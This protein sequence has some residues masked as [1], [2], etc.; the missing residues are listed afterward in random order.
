MNDVSAAADGSPQGRVETTDP[1]AA[2]PVPAHGGEALMGASLDVSPVTVLGGPPD[3]SVAE[4]EVPVRRRPRVR[5]EG[6]RPEESGASPVKESRRRRTGVAIATATG[7]VALAAAPFAVVTPQVRI[8]GDSAAPAAKERHTTEAKKQVAKPAGKQP[9]LPAPAPV[10]TW[11]GRHSSPP[12]PAPPPHVKLSPSS[13]PS[14]NKPHAAKPDAPKPDA[15]KADAAKAD[16]ARAG[17]QAKA[18]PKTLAHQHAE[19]PAVSKLVVSPKKKTPVAKRSTTPPAAEHQ[20]AV[21]TD[22]AETPPPNQEPDDNAGD[23]TAQTRVVHG[24]F[25]L[26]PGESVATDRMRLV[27]GSDGDLVLYDEDGDAVW[28]SDTH[29][30]DAHA[31][32]QADGN[33]VVYSGDDETL[34]SSRTNGHDGAVLVLQADGDLTIRQGDTILWAAGT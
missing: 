5:A 7:V 13:T 18:R 33:L 10:P 32:F 12:V 21:R 19:S 29:A 31:V 34:W 6:G 23:T 24:T 15:A 2:R 3:T 27:L 20:D 30:S 17:H 28:S 9:V 1:P 4:A 22:A 25:V 8:L 26:R 11:Q 14:A 16:A